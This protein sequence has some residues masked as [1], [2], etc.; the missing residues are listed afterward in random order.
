MSPRTYLRDGR[1]PVPRDPRVSATMSRIR[2]KHT[3]PELLVRKALRELGLTGYRLHYAKAPGRPDIT[4]V[5][6]KVAVFV[7]GCFWH[8]CPHCQP[9][10]PKT[11]AGFW[12]AKL[13]RNSERD[14]EKVRALQ[15]AGWTVFTLWECRVRKSVGKEVGRVMRRL[16]GGPAV[17][18]GRR[19][20]SRPK[21]RF[22]KAQKKRN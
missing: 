19:P 22:S 17:Q 14:A 4:F 2:A 6:R 8:G 3:G 18:R 15:Q 11:H 12:N 9:R 5:G 1:A 7:H 21:K 16:A 20:K 13:D 10:R